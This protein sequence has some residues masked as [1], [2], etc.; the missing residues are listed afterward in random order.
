MPHE[1]GHGDLAPH[2]GHRGHRYINARRIACTWCNT[3]ELVP[4]FQR[5]VRCVS[6]NYSSDPCRCYLT[7]SELNLETVE[8]PLEASHAV[9]SGYPRAHYSHTL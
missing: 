4:C 9:L 5:G 1:E 3:Y 6:R 8:L 2:T 7:A